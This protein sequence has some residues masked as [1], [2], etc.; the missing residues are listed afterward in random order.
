MEAIVSGVVIV[1]LFI[2][3]RLYFLVVKLNTSFAKLG[4]VVREDAKKYFDEASSKIVDTNQQF[5][6][7][8]AKIVQDGTQKALSET[9]GMFEEA[10]T[11]AQKEAGDIILRSREDARRIIEAANTESQ[12]K[13][14]EAFNRSAETIRWVMEQY[15]KKSYSIDDHQ[16]AIMKLLNEYINEHRS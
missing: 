15:I 4:Y 3:V 14:N 10:M 11:K 16:D 5:Q 12:R 13:S 6:S 1:V 2:V 8:Y 9:G 7:F